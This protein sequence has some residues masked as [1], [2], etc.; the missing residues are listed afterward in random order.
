MNYS[1]TD[2]KDLVL[3][4]LKEGFPDF[5]SPRTMIS[6]D[7]YF[8]AIETSLGRVGCISEGKE[9]RGLSFLSD[10]ILH[11][12][13]RSCKLSKH[14]AWRLEPDPIVEWALTEVKAYL[15]GTLKA[16]TVP[17]RYEGTFFQQAVWSALTTIPYG[18]QCSYKDVAEKINCPRAYRA[19]GSANRSNPLS[20]I[21]PCHRV[22]A[23]N[24]GLGG[25]NG[26]LDVKSHLL[27]LEQQGR[28]ICL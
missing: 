14:S 12:W 3:N 7:I 22:I 10:K 20:L 16:F 26:G 1:K 23:H 13:L 18:E 4:Y 9:L 17:Y 8:D 27:A 28:T 19:V 24:K 11:S 5:S 21:I 25:Y 15:K 6:S 2:Y